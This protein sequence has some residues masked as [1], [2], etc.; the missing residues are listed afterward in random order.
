[1]W[2]LV[3]TQLMR[4]C[5]PLMTAFSLLVAPLMD[6]PGPPCSQRLT[7]TL[8][9]ALSLGLEPE[10]PAPDPTTLALE[11]QPQPCRP[12]LSAVA[13][14]AVRRPGAPQRH[15]RLPRHLVRHARLR[16]HQRAGTPDLHR[17]TAPPH[18]AA[19]AH[20]RTRP[21]WRAA[22]PPPPH[23]PRCP[24]LDPTAAPPRRRA[25]FPQHASPHRARRSCCSDS[26]RRR[27]SSLQVRSFFI[28]AYPKPSSS[29]TIT[30][31]L[32]LALT[33]PSPQAHSSLT[34]APRPGA[35][36]APCSQSPASLA[37]HAKLTR[38]VFPGAS[39]RVRALGAC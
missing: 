6:P 25:P 11:S 14:R 10:P 3:H 1:M 29:N 26:S 32:I 34:R 36:P 27:A 15:S 19:P 18:P 39:V 17:T 35:L 4:Q 23:R 38:R 30:I 2:P 8:S 37:T 22:A 9:L 24:R 12:A 13:E 33:I 21:H 20:R 28:R 16:P 7:L 5:L 31:T